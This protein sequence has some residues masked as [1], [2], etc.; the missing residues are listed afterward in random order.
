MTKEF[1]EKSK[2]ALFK[3]LTEDHIRKQDFSI[4]YDTALKATETKQV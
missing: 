1:E 3:V 2:L 4:Q